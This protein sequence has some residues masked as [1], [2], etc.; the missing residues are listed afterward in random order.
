MC[1]E[2]AYPGDTINCEILMALLS[3]MSANEGN[4]SGFKVYC[5]CITIG[6]ACDDSDPLGNGCYAVC[7][8]G[9]A[10]LFA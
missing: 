4:L 1:I 2:I 6:D 5:S 7:S 8:V 3:E 9:H 10:T